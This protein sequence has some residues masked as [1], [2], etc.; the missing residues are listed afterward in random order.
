[1]SMRVNSQLQILKCA[2]LALMAVHPRFHRSLRR[3][4]DVVG[5]ALAKGIQNPFLADVAYLLLKPFEW[6]ARGILRMFIR[7][8]DVIAK[9]MYNA[10]M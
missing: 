6:I 7:E 10:S 2:E 8:L 4:Y 3:F 5:R 9:S 1:M